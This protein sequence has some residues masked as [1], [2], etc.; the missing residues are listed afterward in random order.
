LRVNPT[1]CSGSPRASLSWLCL[2][3]QVS[4]NYRRC[5]HCAS[6][7]G[8]ASGVI[9]WVQN[10]KYWVL[11]L[12]HS[13]WCGRCPALGSM[14]GA[15]ASLSV[16]AGQGWGPRERRLYKALQGGHLAPSWPSAFVTMLFLV[17]CLI[18]SLGKNGET[19]GESTGGGGPDSH[20]PLTPISPFSHTQY[21]NLIPPA[22][23]SPQTRSQVCFSF[24]HP[25]PKFL[26]LTSP[27]YPIP[28]SLFPHQIP[29]SSQ[30]LQNFLL[31]PRPHP[32]ASHFTKGAD[33]ESC[34][35][36]GGSKSYQ[37]LSQCQ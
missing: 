35:C 4:M 17:L 30:E 3:D 23:S 32:A 37:D 28:L 21:L 25:H 14:G 19:M 20:A 10:K 34:L 1:P 24:S 11:L 12:L 18:L 13:S 27:H 2:L 16:P 31:L 29:A 36:F 33:R 5:P 15:L 9:L 7:L 22:H 26:P 6:D 8:N